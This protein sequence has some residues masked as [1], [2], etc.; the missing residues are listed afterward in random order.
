M[1]DISNILKRKRI[2]L[3]RE[4]EPFGQEQP[5]KLMNY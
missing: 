5:K 4:L 1:K 3:E 2:F